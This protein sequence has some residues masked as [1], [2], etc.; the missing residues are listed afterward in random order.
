MK[1]CIIALALISLSVAGNA[2]YY[3]P[4]SWEAA[5]K[6]HELPQ[7]FSTESAAFILDRRHI[8]Y[9]PDGEQLAVF[10]TVHRIIKVLD[11][12]G[13][14]SFNKI[15]IV[16]NN[17]SSVGRIQARTILP[18]G[19]TFEIGKEK[20]I[21]TKTDEG[22]PAYVFAMEGIEKGAEIEY[23]FTEKRG[24]AMFGAEVLQTGIPTLKA[25]L[26]LVVP[27]HL[28]FEIKGY[29]GLPASIDTTLDKKHF[30]NITALNVP[31]MDDEQ[32]SNYTASLMKADYRLSYINGENSNVRLNTWNDLAKELHSNYYTIS[33]SD[34]K[35]I[36]KYLK[37]VNV[38]EEDTEDQKIRKIE[39][40]VKTGI[41]ISDDVPDESYLEFDKIV[42]KKLTTEVGFVKFFVACLQLAGVE[43]EFGL[44]TNR[45]DHPLDD[46]F[47]NWK[48]LDIYVI[49]LP[50][51]KKYLAPTSIFTRMPFIP[52]GAIENKA[53][54]CKLTT[55]GDI[56]SAVASIRTIPVLSTEVSSHDIETEVSF[57]ANMVPDIGITH[58]LKGYNAMGM[59]EAFIYVPK[60]KEK[61]LVHEVISIASKHDDISFYK[62][63]NAAFVNYYD[64]K[65]LS[66]I[67]KAVSPQL[68]EK[69]GP[70]YLFKVGDVIGRQVE[71]YQEK[72]RK[73]AIDMPFPHSLY[74]TITINIPAGYK[75][76][77]PEVVQ[78]L[79][80]HKQSNGKQTMGF[81]SD[82]KMEGDK[83]LITVNEFYHETHYPISDI[84]A[85]KKVI[86]AAA[87]FNKA[88]LVLE[89]I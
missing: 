75:V 35:V 39:E 33:E 28:K 44:T 30:Y 56:T 21:F 8:E 12:K 20:I 48:L 27:E 13:V 25:D 84:D 22:Y 53:I 2:Q 82:Y 80:D 49:Y 47:E 19:K 29:N 51:Q 69:A 6:T 32:Y 11:D 43:H 38:S 26:T 46:K 50:K 66:I 74:R 54:L 71:M 63:E 1:T 76:S 59:R 37:S 23:L 36:R 85:F 73:L 45:F 14:E 86:N 15:S 40:A 24:L 5:P 60:E 81:I 42:G 16:V 10:R 41:I 62:V 68:I 7:Q 67:A 79:V 3:L 31:S 9:K 58:S 72:E 34:R 61:E 52:Q 57:D 83:M 64:N 87:D 88:V 70:K 4:V 78:M 89:K 17:A 65:P 55:L 18:N 77:N